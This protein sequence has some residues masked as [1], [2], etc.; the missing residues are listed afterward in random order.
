[1]LVSIKKVVFLLALI[2]WFFLATSKGIHAKET[3]NEIWTTPRPIDAY[4]TVFLEQMTWMEVR[5]AIKSGT[6]SILIPTGGVEQKGPYSA[7][8][9][10]NFSLEVTT[11]IIAEKLGNTLV[12]PVV[13]FVPQGSI[14]PKSRHMRYPGTISV[15]EDIFV[16][17]LI[18]IADSMKAHGF[19]DIILLGDNGGNRAGLAR[20]EQRL[21]EKWQG[22]DSHIHYIEE[23]Y[24]NPRWKKWM[25]ARGIVEVSEGYHDGYRSSAVMMLYDPMM[26]RMPQRLE[27]GLFH[28]NGIDL[29]PMD[30]TIKFAK[31]FVDY[32]TDVTV[33]AINEAVN[34][35][36]QQD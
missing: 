6:T 35:S 22:S 8:G 36:K 15:R 13:A 7:I 23:F 31:E 32:R 16:E 27:K 9:R 26:A 3:D 25:A 12:A 19:T 14:E 18:D 30:K 33:K 21:A 29:M 17:L 10:H 20:A 4:D 28:I 24:D 5:D 1:M 11:K 2:S 34:Q